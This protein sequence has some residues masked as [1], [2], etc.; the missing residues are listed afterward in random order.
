MRLLAECSS[1]RIV[2]ISSV[3]LGLKV[4]AIAMRV[5]PPAPTG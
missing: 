4:K 3:M 2:P 1:N 5:D